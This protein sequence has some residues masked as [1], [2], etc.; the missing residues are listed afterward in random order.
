MPAMPRTSNK[1]REIAYNLLGCP[2]CLEEE[3]SLTAGKKKKKD[4]SQPVESS[5]F[6]LDTTLNSR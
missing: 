2:P 5:D 6:K 4:S 1:A 3:N